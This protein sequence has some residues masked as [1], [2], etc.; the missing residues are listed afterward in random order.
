[1]NPNDFKDMGDDIFDAVQKAIDSQDFSQLSDMIK[2][3]TDKAMNIVERSYHSASRGMGQV[4]QETAKATENW[5]ESQKKK[6]ETLTLYQNTMGEKVISMISMIC[7]GFFTFVFGIT[8]IAMIGMGLFVE[9]SGALL[10]SMVVIVPV[11]LL[12]VWALVSGRRKLSM[13]GRFRQYINCLAGK[14]Y[15][16]LKN[17][18]ETMHKSVEYIQKDLSKMIE[19]GWFLQGHIV[20]DDYCLITSHETYHDYLELQKKQAMLSKQEA[21]RNRQRQNLKPEIEEVLKLGQDYIDS[22]HKSNDAIP[23]EEISKKIATM[24]ELVKKIFEKVEHDP[25]TV[26]DIRKLM[27]YYLP[28]TVKLLDAYEELDKQPVQG[29]NILTSKRE[30]E[31][32]LD[33]LNVAFEKLLDSLF[34]DQAWD[35][36]SDISVLKTMLAQ[37]GLTKEDF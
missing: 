2:S 31:D 7:G 28:M 32:S 19:K 30:I 6:K 8:L 14:T 9:I 5:K 25:E 34:Q 20:S 23:G 3:G 11:F 13:L 27:E 4:F 24:E 12:S 16:D 1:M 15:G 33:A 37:D 36:S 18:S 17:I 35:V 26:D 29:E 22:I 21:E 10:M